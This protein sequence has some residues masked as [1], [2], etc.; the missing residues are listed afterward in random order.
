MTVEGRVSGD[1]VT[2][3]FFTHRVRVGHCPRLA[4]RLAGSEGLHVYAELYDPAGALRA[5]MVRYKAGAAQWSVIAPSMEGTSP[6]CMWGE[7]FEGEW[8]VKAAARP[9]TANEEKIYRIEILENPVLDA[10]GEIL[11]PCGRTFGEGEDGEARWRR[12]DLHGHTAMSD[13]EM[14]PAEK[15]GYADCAGLDFY[16]VTDHDVAPFSWVSSRALPLPGVEITT[17]NGHFN[18]ICP[19]NPLRFLPDEPG[20][21]INSCEGMASLLAQAKSEGA[22]CMLNHPLFAPWHC[23]W[24]GFPMDCVDALE[25]LCD[26]THPGA[27]D[28]AR[29]ALRVWDAMLRDGRRVWG[30]GGSDSHMRPERRCE[31]AAGSSASGD[32]SDYAFATGTASGIVS[33][34]K[35]GN[36][37]V[38][39]GG[40]LD[41][42]VEAGGE[43]FATGRE[44]PGGGRVWVRAGIDGGGILRVVMNRRVLHECPMEGNESAV[45]LDLS[46]GYGYVRAEVLDG[47]GKLRAF[48]N[49]IYFGSKKP[50]MSTW[51]EYKA[52]CG[53]VF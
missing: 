32:P 40:R 4:L 5:G 50:E 35:S 2:Y 10:L 31:G 53:I 47:E 16:A 17:P 46:K 48:S 19:L 13:G 23:R 11:E 14:T 15:A 27:E 6:N 36:V 51:G 39:R 18:V 8:T 21:G 24:D 29:M 43:R 9:T 49:P 20:G 45:R 33:T 41:F 22:F 25:I 52:A 30:V 44:A 28:A 7:L 1:G 3:Y 12:G 26:P 38:S 42:S 37:S 34:L